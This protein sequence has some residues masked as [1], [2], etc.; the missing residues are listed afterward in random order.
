VYSGYLA[1]SLLRDRDH[2]LR[3]PGT[4]LHVTDVYHSSK[5]H[6]QLLNKKDLLVDGKEIFVAHE[7]GNTKVKLA[8]TSFVDERV[9]V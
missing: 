1:N 3:I 8:F 9:P 4:M 6:M 5:T 2:S 7:R